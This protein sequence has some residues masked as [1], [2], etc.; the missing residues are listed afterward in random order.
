[1]SQRGEPNEEDGLIWEY[2]TDRACGS[3]LV[4]GSGR[5]MVIHC[6]GGRRKFVRYYEIQP[7][8]ESNQRGWEGKCGL[9]LSTGA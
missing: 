8:D 4:P 9:L 7:F 5:D 2:D 1:M 3:L 6:K